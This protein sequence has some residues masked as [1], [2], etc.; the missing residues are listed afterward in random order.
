M[1]IADQWQYLI[2][3]ILTNGTKEQRDIVTLH[4]RKHMV[5]M[6]GSRYGAKV[7]FTTERLKNAEQSDDRISRNHRSS[8]T[9][10]GRNSGIVGHGR[11]NSRS[12]VTEHTTL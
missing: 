5:S 4:V 1:E 6:R 10:R 3:Y 7:A 9:S 2:Q 12:V 8:I 11:R